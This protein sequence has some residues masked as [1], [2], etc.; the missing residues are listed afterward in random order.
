MKNLRRYIQGKRVGK[1]AHQIE[2]Q[3][4]KDPFLDDALE[5]YDLLNDNHI[6][7]VNRLHN[8]IRRR[9]QTSTRIPLKIWILVASI[10]LCICIGGYFW[11]THQS[12]NVNRKIVEVIPPVETNEPVT[13]T[14]PLGE[15]PLSPPEI[16]WQATD[17]LTIYQPKD[18]ERIE[19]TRLA[20]IM[21]WRERQQKIKERE[22]KEREVEIMPIQ[23]PLPSSI[24]LPNAVSPVPQKKN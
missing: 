4:M 15:Q 21:R 22:L 12:S 11:K 20:E 24:A 6:K 3:A 19:A 14:E 23:S 17:T 9:F 16:P 8:N 13:V 1:E 18:K 10:L 5:G 7:S 2:L